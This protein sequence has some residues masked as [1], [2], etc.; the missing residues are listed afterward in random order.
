MARYKK[1]Y[2]EWAGVALN[3]L[4]SNGK[5]EDLRSLAGSDPN[6]SRALES[7]KVGRRLSEAQF[8]NMKLSLSGQQTVRGNF[9][10]V[11]A[12]EV[13]KQEEDKTRTADG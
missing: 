2:R 4:A 6:I 11:K 1:K 7:I 9:F 5:L 10:G 8:A 3:T 12:K 13:A